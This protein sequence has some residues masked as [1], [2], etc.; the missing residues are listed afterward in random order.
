MHGLRHSVIVC[1][2]FAPGTPSFLAGRQWRSTQ[3]A[4]RYIHTT[5]QAEAAI[6]AN[7]SKSFRPPTTLLARTHPPIAIMISA[8][9]LVI[10]TIFRKFPS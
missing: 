8:I 3:A 1:G 4:T 7:T 5:S 6:F 10:I 9:L 2:N